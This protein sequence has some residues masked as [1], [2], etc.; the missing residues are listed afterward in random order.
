MLNFEFLMLNGLL[1]LVAVLG[2]VC[3]VLGDFKELDFMWRK[4]NQ[5]NL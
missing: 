3:W 2:V 1:P 4:K 5:V